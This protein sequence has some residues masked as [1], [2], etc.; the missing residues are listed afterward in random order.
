MAKSGRTSRFEPPSPPDVTAAAP[1]P[2]PIPSMSG[3]TSRSLLRN[4]ENIANNISPR[5]GNETPPPPPPPQF[6]EH[7]PSFYQSCNI[8]NGRVI[9]SDLRL[10]EI[11]NNSII[12]K[13]DI[14]EQELDFDL[15]QAVLF[16][17]SSAPDLRITIGPNQTLLLHSSSLETVKFHLDQLLTNLAFKKYLCKP[18]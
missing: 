7:Q 13:A 1:S 15:L 14:L 2:K 5:A 10:F 18:I 17:Q 6:P 12:L 11:Q 4:L 9:W 16:F 8:Y 3:P